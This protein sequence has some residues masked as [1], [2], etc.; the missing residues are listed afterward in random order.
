MNRLLYQ[1]TLQFDI[2][3][4]EINGG[5]LR[6][7]IPRESNALIVVPASKVSEFTTAFKKWV[8]EQYVEIQTI[9][10]DL[11][12]T[13]TETAM[14]QNVMETVAQLAIVRAVYAAHNGVYAMS[15][16][17]SD[18]VETSNNIARVTIAE[19][20]VSIG[21]LTRS[22]VD[23][24][25]MDLAHALEATFTLA[26]CTVDFSG[27]YPGWTPRPDSEILNVLQ[28]QY[29]KLFDEKP[30][31]VACH[32]GLECGILGQ[33]YPDMDMISFGPTIEGAHSPDERVNITSV[34]K[35]WKF[36]LEA[37]KHAPEKKN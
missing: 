11:S 2:Q 27:N 24:A 10:P 34:Q 33:H 3:I 4:A 31:I 9:D 26:G 25:K 21:C 17:I 19:G 16:A 23:T 18:L 6:N 37:L 15:A 1:G 29:E 20:N 12:I 13:L 35:F 28:S 32:A 8:A 5:G 7:A 36:I 30:K 14:P 22:S